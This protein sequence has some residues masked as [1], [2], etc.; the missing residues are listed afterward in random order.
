MC[1]SDNLTSVKDVQNGKQWSGNAA[2]GL[3]SA[4]EPC[5]QVFWWTP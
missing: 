1:Q 4:K 2:E 5:T 3:L